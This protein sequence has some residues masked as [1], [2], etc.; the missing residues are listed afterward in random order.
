MPNWCDLG[1]DCWT[2][3]KAMR[4]ARKVVISGKE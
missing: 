1:D 2:D 3:T 4:Y